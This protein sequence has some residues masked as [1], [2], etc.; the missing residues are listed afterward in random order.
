MNLRLYVYA[1]FH[2]GYSKDDIMNLIKDRQI[3]DTIVTIILYTKQTIES[4]N[5]L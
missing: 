3:K 1:R 4:R 5:P 2:Q